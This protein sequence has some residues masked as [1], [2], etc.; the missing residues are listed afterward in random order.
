MNFQDKVAIVTGAGQGIGRA[1]ARCLAAK[2]AICVIA[3]RSRE[4]AEQTLQ[5]IAEDG[6]RA[7]MVLVDL[8]ERAEIDSLFKTTAVKLGRI[9]L[10]VHNVG[11]T[12]W[13]KPFEHF[14]EE[15]IQIELSRSLMPTIWCCHAV[16]PIMQRQASGAIVN[17]GSVATRGVNRA[18]YAA[19]KGGVA[20]LTTVL[21]LE[22]AER[23]IR[24]NCVSPGGINVGDRIVQR[25]EQT[26]GELDQKGMDEVIRQTLR[27]TPM[28]RFGEPND[29]AAAVCFLGSEEARYIT[30]Q[31]LFVAGGGVG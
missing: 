25:N 5:L 29:I 24:V 18:P 30:G 20:A 16:L 15:E 14:T 27:D 17:I 22:N 1:I 3:E 10:S 26:L 2:G 28:A 9:D 6:G 23:G 12:I 7:E 8:E 31:N 13:T 19:A 21:A 11:G 4:G